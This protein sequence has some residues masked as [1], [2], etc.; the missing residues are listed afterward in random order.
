MRPLPRCLPLAA[1]LALGAWAARADGPI[2][3]PAAPEAAPAPAPP[4]APAPAA[5]GSDDG[6]EDEDDDALYE[7]WATPPAPAPV[8][9]TQPVTLLLDLGAYY[10]SAGLYLPLRATPTPDAGERTEAQIYWSLLRGALVP[11][12]LVLEASVN[13]M[14]CLGLA[15]HQWDWGYRRAQLTPDLNLVRAL[16]AGFD[17]PFAFSLFV[18]NVADFDVRGRRD[19]RGRGYLGLVASGG[20]GHIKDNVLVDDRWLE[21]ELKLKGD[22]ISEEMK[23]SWSF[24]GGVKLHHSPW[25][26]DTAYLGLRRGRVDYQDGSLL[27]ANSG[28]E[29]RFDLSLDGKPLRH[30]LLVDKRWPLG[31]GRAAL[32]LGVGLLW[33]SGAAYKGVLAGHG[34]DL[35][36]LLRPNVVF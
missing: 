22:R 9:R 15:A 34:E 21:V 14:P 6:E 3:A 16:T 10:T 4:S 20:L 30:F 32:V 13:P 33:E 28:L 27:L 36:L 11:R 19:V 25:I 23:L 17:E 29:Y 2:T 7:G 35:Q 12:F 18:G 1:A 5:A 8:P 26:T 24:R 31:R